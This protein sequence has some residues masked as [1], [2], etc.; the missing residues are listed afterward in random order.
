MEE[1]TVGGLTVYLYHGP[2]RNRSPSFLAQQDLVLTTYSTL[3]AEDKGRGLLAVQVCVGGG[4]A[5]RVGCTIQMN[6]QPVDCV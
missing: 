5:W 6:A 1:H 3:A 2:E 4:G